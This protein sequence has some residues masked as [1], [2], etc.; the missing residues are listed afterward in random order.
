[1]I[2]LQQHALGARCSP[3]A[4]LKSSSTARGVAAACRPAVMSAR[5]SVRVSSSSGSSSSNIYYMGID[6]GTSGARVTVIDGE[7]DI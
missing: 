4:K 7:A 6:F 3:E 5:T 1:M 2:G